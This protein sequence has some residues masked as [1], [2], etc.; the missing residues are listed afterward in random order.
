MNSKRPLPYLA[1]IAGI[2]ALSM[3]GIFVRWAQAPGTVTAAYRMG[4]SAL[5]LLPF[6]VRKELHIRLPDTGGG[7]WF[8]WAACSWRA[9]TAFSTPR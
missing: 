3:T 6:F 5:A 4:I 1:L 7:V 2:C 9:I 8:Y